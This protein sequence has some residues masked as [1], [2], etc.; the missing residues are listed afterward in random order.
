MTI[1]ASFRSNKSCGFYSFDKRMCYQWKQS[2]MLLIDF[3]FLKNLSVGYMQLKNAESE[4]K[5]LLQGRTQQF[6][7]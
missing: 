1:L 6:V 7:I 5:C 4:R 2:E 3:T